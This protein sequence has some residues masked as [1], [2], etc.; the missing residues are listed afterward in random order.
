VDALEV[1]WKVVEQC[2]VCTSEEEHEHRA[3]PDVAFL[4]L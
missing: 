1:D 4:D 2:E 3:H